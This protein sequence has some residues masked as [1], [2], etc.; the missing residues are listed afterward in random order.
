MGTV[1]RHVSIPGDVSRYRLPN[2]TITGTDRHVADVIVAPSSDNVNNP[3][4]DNN[5]VGNNVIVAPSSDNASPPSNNVVAPDSS[6]VVAPSS[7]SSNV[8]APSSDSSNVVAPASNVLPNKGAGSA[9]PGYQA[10][11]NSQIV[12]FVRVF[13]FFTSLVFFVIVFYASFFIL[14]SNTWVWAVS[15]VVCALG[16]ILCWSLVRHKDIDYGDS[17][18]MD[19]PA[20]KLRKIL[21]AIK[22]I[23]IADFCLVSIPTLLLNMVPSAAAATKASMMIAVINKPNVRNWI[24]YFF[25]GLSALMTVLMMSYLIKLQLDPIV[26]EG[27]PES[28]LVNYTFFGWL[29]WVS[30]VVRTVILGVLVFKVQNYKWDTAPITLTVFLQWVMTLT[31]YAPGSSF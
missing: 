22:G 30:M 25:T 27:F 11:V 31:S 15:G 28:A 24:R 7:D 19:K 8:V 12:A 14:P 6:N 29:I 16:V 20:D 21:W 18:R 13:M 4:S 23:M 9:C 2:T 1:S 26:K 17:C 3:S 10:V 5:V